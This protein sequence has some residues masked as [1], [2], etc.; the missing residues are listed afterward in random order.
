LIEVFL[1]KQVIN[2]PIYNRD[3]QVEGDSNYIASMPSANAHDDKK[4]TKPQYTFME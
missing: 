1:G 4:S 3:L 2:I